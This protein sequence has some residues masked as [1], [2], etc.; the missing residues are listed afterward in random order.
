M[1]S[2]LV[3]RVHFNA[4]IDGRQMPKDA[5]R[6]G[7]QAG[8]QGG[9]GFTEEWDKEFRKGLTAQGKQQ[10]AHWQRRGK[11]DGLAY[12]S[13]LE[14][15][16]RRF[17]SRLNS[18][19]DNFQGI[20]VNSDFMDE[21]I[22][23][24]RNWEERVDALR[25]DLDLLQRQGAITDTQYRNSTGV[26]DRWARGQH[27]AGLQARLLTAEQQRQERSLADLQRELAQH[28]RARENVL[29]VERDHRLAIRDTNRE[30]VESDD[31]STRMA[32]NLNAL[33]DRL[34]ETGF[35][36]RDLSHN[37]RQWTL[38]IGAVTAALP[39]LAGLSSAAGSGLVTL[40][41]AA[42]GAG[43]GLTSAISS[44][45]VLN[46]DLED[47]PPA[48]YGARRGLD[49]FK[50][51]FGDLGET[52]AIDALS[53]AE[54]D[55]RS[56]GATVR[57]LEPAFRPVNRVVGD[58]VRELAEGLAPG[59]RNFRNLESV[60][61]NSAPVFDSLAS[62]AGRIGEGLL[63]AF[64]NPA[65]VRSVTGFTGYVED[66][67]ET[68]ASFLEG[69]GLDDW[70]RHGEAVFGSFGGLLSTT[71]RLL[72]DLVTPGSISRLTQF[73]DSLGTFL[74]TGGR[75]ILEFADELNAFG[76]IAELLEKVGV[77]LEPLRDPMADLAAV[78]R[79]AIIPSL[80]GGAAALGAVAQVAG[81]V[82]QGLADVI[83]AVPP[84]AWQVVGGGLV[85][86]ATG[87]G[88]LAAVRGVSGV[89]DSLRGIHVE[90]GKATSTLGKIGRAAGLLGAAVVGVASLKAGLDDLSGSLRDADNVSRNAVA[91][92]QSISDSAKQLGFD[93]GTLGE[94]YDDILNRVSDMDNFFVWAT[95]LDSV[96]YA[97]IGLSGTLK[98][99]DEPITSLAET[100]L[101]AASS[102][103][104]AWAA[105]LGASDQQVLGLLENMPEFKQLLIDVASEADGTATDTELLNL[106]LGRGAEATT[107]MRDGLAEVTGSAQLTGEQIDELSNK[108][109]NFGDTQLTALEAQS[110]FEQAFDDLT[111]SVAAN[112]ATL[113]L[114]TQSG[115][116]NQS[117]IIDL[118]RGT[119]DYA[120]A[121]LDQTGDQ[122]AANAVL[123]DGRGRLDEML[124]AF[125]DAGGSAEDYAAYLGA[126]PDDVTTVIGADT[127]AAQGVINGFISAND[128]RVITIQAKINAAL[129]SVANT[130]QNLFP[131]TAVG[132]TFHGSQIREIAEDGPEAVVPLD[133]P[134]SQVDRSVRWLSAIAQGLAPVPQAQGSSGGA[135]A[136]AQFGAGSIVISEARSARQTA[137]ELLDAITESV[138]G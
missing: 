42:T 70:L 79:D 85:F 49:D 18:A 73:M 51:S 40:G 3:G 66:L 46:R 96:G 64:A 74:D 119:N 112:G 83:G 109:R 45:V 25:G 123:Q 111:E 116:D 125:I 113:D 52:M 126:I 67:S 58:L 101:S 98:D 32:R 103:F 53:G 6:I 136:G 106:A 99:L 27:E 134:L 28:T 90:G 81:P 71:G 133:R 82:A 9:K 15:E 138:T 118:I 38:I 124:Q 63:D 13:G 78:V 47:L 43:F 21:W 54:R 8:L 104:A 29:R 48:L 108:I 132:G 34:S 87:L 44:I 92:N 4:T 22:G 94:G 130:A 24:S 86:V 23:K 60:V 2:N 88:A 33:I 100:D 120:A 65:M 14:V 31:L 62:S 39:E 1:V 122:E 93:I 7:K 55:F 11:V 91:T 72:N 95:A 30:W 77:A 129:A 10:L 110:S 131:K 50:A 41:A 69:D 117:S 115:R 56:L 17:S 59:T 76:V 89:V 84:E 19:F 61:S 107:G 68:F 127:G 20:S 37:A 135:S 5:E 97:A 36:F 102:Q 137:L 35:R 26:V 12:G 75:G 16:F 105:E 121:I 114:N 128:G 80:E 57:G